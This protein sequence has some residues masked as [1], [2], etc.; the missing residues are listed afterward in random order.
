M[1]FV[2]L[3]GKVYRTTRDLDLLGFGTAEVGD[4]V[5]RIAEVCSVPA[6]DGIVFATASIGA[7]R[8]R[9]DTVYEGVRVWVPASLDGATV[10]IQWSGPANQPIRAWSGCRPGRGILLDNIPTGRYDHF[11]PTGWYLCR[12]P[13]LLQPSSNS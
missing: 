12:K 9:K 4:V 3:G 2:A 5:A 10:T 11:V 7:E 1:L 6:N 8:I 13:V